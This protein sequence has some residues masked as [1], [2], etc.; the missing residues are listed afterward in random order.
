MD[1]DQAAALYRE[2]HKKNIAFTGED[3]E[4]FHNM[5][6]RMVASFLEQEMRPEFRLLDY[7]CGL[8]LVTRH[9]KKLLPGA[10]IHGADPSAKSIEIAASE[11][12]GI[13][14]RHFDG[15]I[16]PYGEDSFDAAVLSCVLHHV[17][18]DRDGVYSEA[19]RVLRPGKKLFI[20]DHN[21]FNPLTRRAVNTC[22]FDEDAKLIGRR[23]CVKDL[24]RAGF[25]ILEAR[26]IV[27]FPAFLKR[28]RP[29]EGS[30]G[31]LPLGG[32]YFI[33][34]TKEDKKK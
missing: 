8:G 9:L 15:K 26:Y 5:K 33:C 31:W 4:Y 28:F 11:N 10:E 13:L 21:P 12:E 27:F 30:L 7:G 6:A 2:A 17:D 29:I 24:E 32:Q 16:A 18:T 1:F 3:P 14:F 20:F 23:A 19:H 34:A 25:R 22:V